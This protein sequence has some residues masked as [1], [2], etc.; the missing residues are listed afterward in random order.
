MWCG[1]CQKVLEECVCDDLEERIS[2]ITQSK[3]IAYKCCKKCGK[4]YALCKCKEPDWRV[5]LPD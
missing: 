5:C 4:H 2:K 3:Y 1:K